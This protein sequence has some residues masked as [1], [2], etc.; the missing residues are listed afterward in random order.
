[1]PPWD[2]Y[3]TAKPW[4]KFAPAET[5]QGAGRTI[6]DQSMQGATFG[7]A[8]EAQDRIGAGIAS[9]ATGEDYSALLDEAR[10]K[11]K[12]RLQA[13][14]DQRPV[15]SIASNLGGALLT[16]GAGASTKTGTAAGNFLRSGNLPARIAKGA[17]AGAASGAAYG[18]G[19]SE[20]R[21]EGAGQGALLGGVV[22][23][24]VPA[25]GAAANKLN[26][27][28]TV[29]TS[30]QVRDAGSKAFEFAEKKGGALNE[31]VANKFYNQVLKIRPQ[32]MEGRVFKGNSPVTEIY[33]R[34][35]ELFNRPMTLRA[36]KE[37]DEALGDMAY[38]TMDKFGKL[39]SDG[40]K[41]LDMQTALRRTM[42]NA[43]ESMVV[44]GKEGFTAL[45]EAR[46]IWATSLRM[47]DLERI[48]DNAQR[49]DN[50]ATGIRTG[51]RTLLRNGDRLKGY[52]PQEIK[53]IEKAANTGVVTDLLRL[54]G[55][56]LVPIGSGI[57][58]TTAGGGVVGGMLGAGAGAAI[59][60]SSKAIAASR[61]IGRAEAALQKVAE[62]SGMVEQTK[63]I[64]ME[65]LKR[66]FDAK[67]LLKG[68][69]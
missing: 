48:I 9:L 49:M 7:F 29:P 35:P 50:P 28:T 1:M 38:S 22:G 19:T 3:Q 51:F 63:R 21:L 20:D 4:E 59:Q 25:I 5:K 69:P 41:F 18:A 26:T 67:K 40:K 52:T 36:A 27:K 44:G 53:A 13:Q 11:S 24:A 56:G 57:A 66:L 37:V 34:I 33:D 6:F 64:S 16:G 65:E 23:G 8:D 39:T 15:L 58:G 43:D 55:S 54:A 30:E 45:K 62:R 2:Q 61:Q 42:D 68:R 10:G 14:F 47:R 31:A 60:Q 32:T 12:E 46:K 17:V